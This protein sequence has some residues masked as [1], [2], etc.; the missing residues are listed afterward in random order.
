MEPWEATP[1]ISSI[2]FEEHTQPL[3]SDRLGKLPEWWIQM[4][5]EHTLE[6]LQVTIPPPEEEEV[7]QDATPPLA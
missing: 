4:Y 7:P 6:H 1:L 5:T 3:A 2:H